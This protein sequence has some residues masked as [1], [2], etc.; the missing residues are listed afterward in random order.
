MTVSVVDVDD[1]ELL[2]QLDARAARVVRGSLAPGS[3]VVLLGVARAA[4]LGAIP[5]AAAAL[6]DRGALWVLHPRGVAEV[7]DTAIFAAAKGAGLTYTKVARVSATH[8][9]E[10]LVRPRAR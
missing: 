7:Q 5:R 1:A 3:E 10:K 2:A 9:A 8:T 6:A 4:D